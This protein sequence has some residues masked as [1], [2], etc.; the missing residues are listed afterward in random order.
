MS[1]PDPIAALRD[2]ATAAAARDAVAAYEADMARYDADPESY[3][4]AVAMHAG[5][6]ASALRSVLAGIDAARG[7]S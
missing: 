3:P 7:A 1:A 6:L 5:R 4:V 2:S